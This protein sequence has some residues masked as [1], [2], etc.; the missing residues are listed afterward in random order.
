[1]NLAQVKGDW[2]LVTGASSGI[3]R[4]FC[5][6]LAA[7]G[8][9]LVLVARRQERL[10]QLAA[11]L[12]ARHGTRS[13]IVL[14]DLSQPHAAGS[15][16]RAVA[17]QGVR[18]RLLVNNAASGRWGPFEN[19]STEFH[20]DAVQLI[21]STTVSL[22]RLFLPDL[23]SFKGS[24]VINLSSAAAHQPVC[25]KAVY[26]AAKAFVHHFS[27]ALHGEWKR[28]G[29]LVQTL[30]PWPTQSEMDERG[31]AY[32]CGLSPERFP[33]EGVVRASLMHLGQGTALVTCAKG[34][35]LQR[36]FFGL[37]PAGLVIQKVEK[38]F[39]PPKH[40]EGFEQ[41]PLEERAIQP[42]RFE[43]VTR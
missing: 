30:I 3:G 10:E 43:A 40:L 17:A 42:S 13:H 12:G 16:K 2:A 26:A 31:G 35:Y 27:L 39:R 33:P 4:E 37:F 23:A 41:D 29:I 5:V 28:R 9:H 7:A 14:Q 21:A 19:S 34:T 15:V 20:A 22:C 24:A 25:Y 8:M 6:Q 1:M 11:E 18:I 36:L 38:M 32:P